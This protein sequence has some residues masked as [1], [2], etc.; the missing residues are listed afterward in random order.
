MVIVHFKAKN[1]ISILC[2]SCFDDISEEAK[3]RCLDCSIDECLECFAISANNDEHHNHYFK[4]VDLLTVGSNNNWK[5]IDEFVLFDCLKRFGIGNFDEISQFI[6]KSEE[7]L[8][9]YFS[10]I[11]NI[12]RETVK[13]NKTLPTISNPNFFKVWSYMPKREDLDNQYRDEFEKI[14]KDIKLELD[15]PDFDIKKELLE[16]YR[17]VRTLRKKRD[18]FIISRQLYNMPELINKENKFDNLKRKIL[19]QLK[20]FSVFMSK[21]DFNIFL[22]G[23]Y[24]EAKYE[25]IL[26]HKVPLLSKKE[27]EFIRSM[28]VDHKI[29]YKIK[30]KIVN[31]KIKDIKLNFNSFKKFLFDH[32]QYRMI[33]DF[34]GS[35]YFDLS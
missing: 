3:V 12:R 16:N 29:Y 5:I 19:K 11:F 20:P 24:Q 9:K 34:F 25:E 33:V 15:D 13:S 32:T 28:N 4:V 18:S 17:T 21:N 14:I 23:L 22:Q 27:E 30:K 8:E 7:E 31:S 6:C 10:D 2:N 26:T 35:D 1:K